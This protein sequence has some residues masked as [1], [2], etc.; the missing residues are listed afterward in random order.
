MRKEEE[1]A[2][3]WLLSWPSLQDDGP[4]GL[5]RSPMKWVSGD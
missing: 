3:D 2:Q 4:L 5:G 1:P